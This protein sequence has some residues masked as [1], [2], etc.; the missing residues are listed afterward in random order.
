MKRYFLFDLDGTVADN[1]EGI[2]KSAQ[3]ALDA[4]GIHNEPE[5]R[6]RRFVGPPLHES[7]MELYG[8]SREQAFAAVEKY[9]ER[10]RGKGVYENQLYPGMGALLERLSQQAVVCLATSKP[11][12]FARTILETRQ[13]L[14]CFQV[15]VGAELDGS[16]TDKAEVIQAVLEKLGHPPKEQAVMI[17]DRKHDILGAKKVG[18]ESIGVQYGFA[19]PGEL[20]EAGAEWIVPTVADLEKLCLSLCGAGIRR[21]GKWQRKCWLWWTCRT[22]SSPEAWAPQ[23]PRPLCPR[24]WRKSRGSGGRCSTPR[25]PTGRITSPNP[26]GAKPA[27]GALPEGHLGLAAGAPGGGGARQHPH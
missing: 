20:E 11:E 15:V 10:Y 12:V 5:E 24:W 25:T 1:G 18:L 17:G 3:Y 14:P 8:F 27:G 7:F 2:L 22:T 9:R 19:P 26:G 13:V 16:R 6:L 21:R 4:F 23:R